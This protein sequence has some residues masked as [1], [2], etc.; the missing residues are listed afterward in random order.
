MRIIAGDGNRIN[1][2][3]DLNS[4]YHLLTRHKKINRDQL[5]WINSTQLDQLNSTGST[6]L[7]LWI[8]F[9]FDMD[10]VDCVE[11]ETPR[12]MYAE[13]DYVTN[14]MKLYGVNMQCPCLCSSTLYGNI[15]CFTINVHSNIAHSCTSPQ[16]PGFSFT[17]FIK[18]YTNCFLIASRKEKLDKGFVQQAYDNLSS[19]VK[20]NELAYYVCT[21]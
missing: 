15:T 1:N 21:L 14:K 16:C 5:N 10:S 12:L 7:N 17:H 18:Q 3:I 20:F 11:M 19:V 6:Q 4:F 13:Y 8:N 2:G 9:R